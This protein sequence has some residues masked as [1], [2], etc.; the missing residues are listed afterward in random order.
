MTGDQHT[1][2]VHQDRVGP[3]P[4]QDGGGD[5]LDVGRA[6]KPRIVRIGDQPFDR[7]QLDPFG[8]P[9]A[10]SGPPPRKRPPSLLPALRDVF[11][12]PRG[13]YPTFPGFPRVLT[14]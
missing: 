14:P 10:V 7:P 13:C 8:W 9:L 2:F 4:F 3:P 12:D 11:L 6:V 5:P 1:L